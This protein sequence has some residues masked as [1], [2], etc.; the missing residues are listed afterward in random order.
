[1]CN[2]IHLEG[3]CKKVEVLVSEFFESGVTVFICI[4]S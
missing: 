3:Y 4:F 2:E 1:M